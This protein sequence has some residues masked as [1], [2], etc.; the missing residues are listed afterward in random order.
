MLQMHWPSLAASPRSVAFARASWCYN[1][2]CTG[3]TATRALVARCAV[4]VV[5]KQTSQHST[6][7]WTTHAT[8]CCSLAACVLWSYAAGV[9]GIPV[10]V[11]G[12][13]RRQD[14]MN[15]IQEQHPRLIV[16]DYTT[17]NC[18][19]GEQPAPAR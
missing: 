4:S 11:V 2:D 7:M 19:N 15:R 13:E 16:V 17:P 5:Q 18:V 10:E 14:I 8:S 9:A 1:F 12:K 6:S 3:A